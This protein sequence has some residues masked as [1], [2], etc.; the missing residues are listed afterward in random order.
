MYIHVT[1]LQKEKA[2]LPWMGCRGWDVVLCTEV[3]DHVRWFKDLN[4]FARLLVVSVG[5]ERY[6]V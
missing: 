3:T 1:V 6:V 4:E 2:G 5:R